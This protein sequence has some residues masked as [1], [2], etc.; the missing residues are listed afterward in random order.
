MTRQSVHAHFA[1]W[2]IYDVNIAADFV[3]SMREYLQFLAATPPCTWLEKRFGVACLWAK[4]S[5][6]RQ[7]SGQSMT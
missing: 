7:T 5:P 4:R 2:G 6:G 1:G 3:C